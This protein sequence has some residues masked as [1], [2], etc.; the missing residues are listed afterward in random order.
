MLGFNVGVDPIAE[1][2]ARERGI[3]IESFTI[4]Y[5]LTER[6]QELLEATAPKRQVET[7]VGRAKVL[8]QFST[9]KDECVIGGKVLEGYLARKARIRVMR[10]DVRVGEG[11]MKNIQSN[12]QD[13]DRIEEGREFGAQIIADFEIVGGDILECFV[14]EMK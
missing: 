10:R 2:L 9:R 13:V 3:R 11:K 1:A 6:L 5:K 8:K 4:I 14:N 12:K 7:V